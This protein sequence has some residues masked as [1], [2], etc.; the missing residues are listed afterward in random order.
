MTP[1][2]NLAKDTN[3]YQTMADHAKSYVVDRHGSHVPVRFDQ[4]TDRNA[5][6]CSDPKYGPVLAALDCPMITAMV[7]GRFRPGMTTRELDAETAALC[8]QLASHHSDYERL[9]A[10]IFISDL[11]KR[12]PEASSTMFAELYRQSAATRLSE[13]FRAVVQMAP[14]AIDMALVP[15]R[16]YRLRFFGF[17][18]MARSYLLRPAARSAESSLLDDQLLERPQHLYM[19]VALGIFT[20]PTPAEC[21]EL[22]SLASSAR[23]RDRVMASLA[24]A[25]EFYNALSLQRVSNATPTMLNAGTIV[26]QLSS[27]FQF[28]TG[29]D[30]A[31][32]F[33][34]VKGVALTSKWSGGVSVWLHNVRASGAVIRS[35]NGHSSGIKPYIKILND[36]QIYVNQG[37]NRP[38][39]FAV[40][41]SVDHDDVFELLAAARLKGEDANKSTN[42][43]DLKYSLWVPDLFMEAL[44][45]QVENEMRV[46][47]GGVD[48]VRAGDWHLFSP[49]E[50]PGLHLVCGDEYRALVARYVA[51]GRHR[52]VVKAKDIFLEAFKTW[53]QGGTPYWLNKDNINRFSNL[54]NVAPICSGNLCTEVLMPSWSRHDAPEFARFHPDNAAGGEVGVCNLAALCLESF[55]IDGPALPT[56]DWKEIRAA[57]ALETRVLNRVIDQTFYPTKDC[58]RS[59]VRHRPIGIGIMGLADV[60]VRLKLAYGSP[61]ALRV[62]RGIAAV[63]YFSAMSESVALAKRDGPYSSYLGSPASNGLLQPDL[64]HRAGKLEDDWPA[65]VAEVTNGLIRP[66]DW[67]QL[68]HDIAE[69]GLRNCYVTAYMPTATT[70]NIV[71]QNECFEPFTSNL[72]TRKTLAGEFLVVNRHLMAELTSLGLW[73]DTM[74]RAVLAAGGSIQQISAIPE[75]IRRRYRTARELHPTLILRTAQAMSPFI[76][77]GMSMNVYFNDLE[78]SKLLRFLF[79]GWRMGLKTGMYYCHSRP[80]TGTQMTSVQKPGDDRSDDA[81]SCS[82][83][84][85]AC[86]V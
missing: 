42:S 45:K 85:G 69:F 30:L 38:G 49:D 12:T 25:F 55:L 4:I 58:Q 20:V 33:R 22:G 6:L 3:N 21:R 31:Q 29:D 7:A 67:V 66:E 81:G 39:A 17:Q 1:D 71:G 50:A 53:S 34:T 74:R 48:D 78:V 15:E 10:R 52:R 32:L 24:P 56:L 23:Q 16:D 68:R 27:C 51:E 75:A 18:T 37:G 60:L 64:W 43:P 14:A 46:L 57:A 40:Y 61:D 86:T 84:G 83:A 47:N 35:T 8:T 13:S 65:Q 79:E 9:A 36:V 44:D 26:P 77:Q 19:R 2:L 63:I 5:A 80:E 28:G 73:D 82:R 11:H 72:Y 54:M 76:C 62:A 59:N 41:L 70:S